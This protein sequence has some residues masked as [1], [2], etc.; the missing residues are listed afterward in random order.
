STVYRVDRSALAS[1]SDDPT[2]DPSK[3]ILLTAT[4]EYNKKSG[5][6][7]LTIGQSP[8]RLVWED[9]SVA[10]LT[11]AKNSDVYAFTR[12]TF[13]DSPQLQV[14]SGTFTDAKVIVGTNAFLTDYAWSKQT[15]MDYTNKHGD[16][17]QMMLTYPANYAPG[18]KYPMVVY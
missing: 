9:A 1:D 17:L 11:K 16:K 8:S 12:Q 10:G 15:L 3:P 13:N 14:S 7:R 18:K 2:I 6:S 4:G 5:F